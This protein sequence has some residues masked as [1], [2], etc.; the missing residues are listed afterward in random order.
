MVGR[1]IGIDLFRPELRKS[2][3]LTG[4]AASA[5]AA[6]PTAPNGQRMP[7]LLLSNVGPN[8]TFVTWGIGA[9]VAG[10]TSP[11]ADF[12]VPVGV[13]IVVSALGADNIACITPTGSSTL[14]VTPGE[15][16]A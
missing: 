11:T 9:Q 15:G 7:N 6:I 14:W 13:A 16:A 5:N 4:G 2:L 3:S 12:P 1:S 8:I 10:G